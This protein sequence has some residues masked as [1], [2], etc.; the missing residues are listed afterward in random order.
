MAAHPDSSR[1]ADAVRRARRAERAPSGGW[2]TIAAKEMADHLA[3][4]R[5]FVL[6]LVVAV[7][8]VVPLV[9]VSQEITADAPSLSGLPA[10]FLALF[11]ASNQTFAMTTVMFVGILVPLVGIAFG[12]DGINAERNQGTLSRLLA[13][14][15]HRDDVVNGK[16]AAGL[17][18]IALMVGA[19]IALVAAAGIMALGIIPSPEEIAR[20]LVWFL[21]TVLYASF[22]L[23]FAL[24]LSVVIRSSASAALVGFGT[25]LGLVLFGSFLLPL[26]ARAIF[27]I[28]PSSNA[29]LFASASAQQLFV[30]IS[31]AQLYADIGGAVLNPRMTNVIGFGNVGQAISSQEQL[32]TL[33]SLDQSILLVWPQIVLLVALTVVMF[34]LAYVLFLRQE[35]RA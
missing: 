26:V 11:I 12:F 20:I 25:W 2:R 29:S 15:I 8:A 17:A 6:L 32:P 4:T 28:D 5:F 19:L 30:R 24:L 23:A 16:F 3:S 22:W 18:V 9:F 10:L 7:A 1:R 31:P 21:A 33:L 35:V 27:P 13:Q 34:A 14:P